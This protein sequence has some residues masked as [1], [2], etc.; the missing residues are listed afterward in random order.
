MIGARVVRIA[1]HPEYQK[2][3][4]GSRCLEL[5]TQ[6][7]EGSFYDPSLEKGSE[8][9]M[10]E[11]EDIPSDGNLLTELV[12]PRKIKKPLLSSLEERKHENLQW[13]GV[14]Y[15]V[16]NGKK[17]KLFIIYYFIYYFIFI[18]VFVCFLQFICLKNRSI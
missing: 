6:Y 15:G 11:M 9:E 17:K 16:T 4:Y 7:Y 5:L 14:S 2:M 10:N 12:Q 18:F 8:E 13:L 3:G 1:T